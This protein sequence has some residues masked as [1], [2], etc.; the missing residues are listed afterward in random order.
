LPMVHRKS[1]IGG[2]PAVRSFIRSSVVPWII[3]DHLK[4]SIQLIRLILL[5]IPFMTIIN[6][7]PILISLRRIQICQNFINFIV[8]ILLHFHHCFNSFMIHQKAPSSSQ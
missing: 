8:W 1:Q 7:S 5:S 6:L 4:Y 2:S 3:H